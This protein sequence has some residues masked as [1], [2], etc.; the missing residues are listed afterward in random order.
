MATTAKVYRTDLDPASKTASITLPTGV[1]VARARIQG[2]RTLELVTYG[3][4]A[5]A[6]QS[7]TVT[8]CADTDAVP[9]GTVV[10]AL[11]WPGNLLVSSPLVLV[12][13]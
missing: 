7:R 1:T 12:L 6:T 9:A 8:L 13:S 11:D 10:G 2:L 4:Q 5:A 3:D